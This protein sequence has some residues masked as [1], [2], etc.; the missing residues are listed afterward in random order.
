MV[1][2]GLAYYV[3]ALLLIVRGQNQ[4]TQL[5]QER[6]EAQTSCKSLLQ[7]G[8]FLWNFQAQEQEVECSAVL[9]EH[10]PFLGSNSTRKKP[11]DI[12]Y[13][14][15]LS[16]MSTADAT[17]GRCMPRLQE[18]LDQ[19]LAASQEIEEQ[20]PKRQSQD[21][22]SSRGEEAREAADDGGTRPPDD[23]SYKGSM[24]SI[25]A[26]GK[27]SKSTGR[28]CIQGIG[29]ATAASV[30]TPTGD[31]GESV[32][33]SRTTA[34]HA[35]EGI[36]RNGGCRIDAAHV[37]A[38]RSSGSETEGTSCRQGAQPWPCQS[39][40]EAESSARGNCCQ[41]VGIGQG[42]EEFYLQHRAE[43]SEASSFVSAMSGRNCAKQECEDGRAQD[44]EGGDGSSIPKDDGCFTSGRHAEHRGRSGSTHG[45]LSADHGGGSRFGQLGVRRRDGNR[46]TRGC[47]IAQGWGSEE[48]A[49]LPRI[50]LPDQSGHKPSQS[51][52]RQRCQ[53]V[54]ARLQNPPV[55]HDSE[56]NLND[57]L[58]QRGRGCHEVV[59]RT[60]T[61]SDAYHDQTGEKD[62][63]SM[64]QGFMLAGQ[65]VES[66]LGHEFQAAT[67]SEYADQQNE[68]GF[69]FARVSKKDRVVSFDHTVELHILKGNRDSVFKMPESQMPILRTFWH[70]HGQICTAEEMSRTLTNSLANDRVVAEE[71]GDSMWFYSG[72][73][74][75][76]AWNDVIALPPSV[77]QQITIHTWYLSK[78]RFELCIRSRPVELPIE[79]DNEDFEAACRLAWNDVVIPGRL[80]AFLVS[81][82]PTA[83]ARHM[84]FIL[85]QN[86]DID[87]HVMLLKWDPGPILFKHRAVMTHSQDLPLDVL[88]RAQCDEICRRERVTCALAR[89]EHGDQVFFDNQV[90]CHYA[91][92]ELMHAYARLDQESDSDDE[93]DLATQQGSDLGDE[94]TT[95]PQ[96]DEEDCQLED[97][98]SDEA[99]ANHAWCEQEVVTQNFDREPYPW[100]RF[101]DEDDDANDIPQPPPQDDEVLIDQHD[102]DAFTIQVNIMANVHAQTQPTCLAI[103]YGVGLVDLGRRDLMFAWNDVH[104][105]VHRIHQLWLDHAA[106]GRLNIHFVRIQPQ[107]LDHRPYLVFLDHIDYGTM[108]LND[109]CVLMHERGD[110]DSGCRDEPYGAIV[111]T[112]ASHRALV[113]QLGHDQCFHR[114]CVISL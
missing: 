91:N 97:S 50:S 33:R 103:T 100:E 19:S 25:Y 57:H 51:Q 93:N 45:S 59:T 92:G 31:A 106:R 75:M 28:G 85:V 83:L 5:A 34:P 52:D 44:V 104:T 102:I 3:C 41:I 46:A 98:S 1:A 110:A 87:Q 30:T 11:Q 49:K 8:S 54:N 43:S 77:P 37:A 48:E 21:F 90:P 114:V 74:L 80:D 101:Q 23:G 12:D 81:P 72:E 62:F 89:I 108:H 29:Y 39:Q 79:A 94:S 107:N 109:R 99:A 88:R 60:W 69:R 73:T 32:H 67:W 64:L 111:H 63:S 47:G 18:A 26:S 13:D 78:D 65:E 68:L 10:T 27:T 15:V 82:Q 20:K 56:E 55:F 4:G 16:H 9:A 36:E 71:R 86:L 113:A 95:I 96:V 105:L 84:H 2:F 70:L 58:I 61:E 17:E 6:A 53:E 24:D 112:H 35:S 40:Q 7:Q 38:A 76:T 42:V 14:L 22:Q 66:Q